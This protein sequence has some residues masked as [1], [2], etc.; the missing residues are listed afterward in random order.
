MVVGTRHIGTHIT[1][2]CEKSTTESLVEGS[3]AIEE[4]LVDNDAKSNTNQVTKL[5]ERIHRSHNSLPFEVDFV[6]E[7]AVGELEGDDTGFAAMLGRG[8]EA[9]EVTDAQTRRRDTTGRHTGLLACLGH[10]GNATEEALRH[11]E[12]HAPHRRRYHEA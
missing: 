4:E 6:D 8:E 9:L 7:A 2:R 1:L 12:P 5:V 10:G 11:F 3:I